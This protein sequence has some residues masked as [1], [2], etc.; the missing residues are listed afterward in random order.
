MNYVR[1]APALVVATALV[2]AC[3]NSTKTAQKPPTSTRTDAK[4]FAVANDNAAFF[5]RGPQAGRTPDQTLPKETLVRLIRPSFGFSKVELVASHEQGYVASD[6]LKPAT[7]ALVAATTA[8]KVDPLTT[9]STQPAAEMFRLDS[10]DPRL[11][12]PPED[13]PPSE[14]PTPPPGQ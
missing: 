14:L 13:L 6:D 11:I 9:P 5:R 7:A 4:L 10:S 3:S 8:P 12:P 1:F 2:V